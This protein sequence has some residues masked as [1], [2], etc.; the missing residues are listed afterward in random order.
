[1]KRSSRY[2][3]MRILVR[4]L[5]LFLQIFQIMFFFFFKGRIFS[6]PFQAVQFADFWLAD[7]LTSFEFIFTDLQFI[8][9]YYLME[10]T[11]SPFKRMLFNR[12]EDENSILLV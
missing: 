1:M 12:I 11:F 4:R 5:K 10:T 6:A 8:I 9:C 3:L 2:W 7:Q